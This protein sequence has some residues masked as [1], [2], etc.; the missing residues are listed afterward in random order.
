[1]KT[2]DQVRAARAYAAVPGY[3]DQAKGHAIKLPAML[4]HNGLLATWAFFLSK[5][6][7]NPPVLPELCAH[8]GDAVLALDVQ[9]LPQPYE[10]F[11]AW[12]GST[13]A[14]D[15]LT[16]RQLRDL[17]AEAIAF[18]GWLKRAAEAFGATA[19]QETAGD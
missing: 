4:H 18:A 14:Q 19:T 12:V 3:D 17:T 15:G 16:S 10:T 8:L 1:V 9:V 5:S 13:G 6:R 7:T 11:Q 2:L